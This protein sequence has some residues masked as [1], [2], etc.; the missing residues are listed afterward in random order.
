MLSGPTHHSPW[1]WN[2]GE[3]PDEKP[4]PVLACDVIRIGLL[5]LIM[6]LAAGCGQTAAPPSPT[7]ILSATATSTVPPPTATLTATAPMTPIPATPTVPPPTPTVPPPTRDPG[8][9]EFRAFWVDAFHPG[10]KSPAEAD[11]LIADVQAA[12]ANAVVVQVRRRGDALYN[13]GFEP[14]PPSWR[15]CPTM[16]RWR[17][18]WPRPTPPGRPSRYTPG[19]WRYRSPRAGNALPPRRTSISSTAPMRPG[20]RC[21]SRAPRRAA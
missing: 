3:T 10:I 13:L 21:G 11:K 17:T 4:R 5:A 1:Q 18:W 8:R 7:A 12:N 2:T 9:A 15:S 16:T 6:L 14:A 20:K 19:S